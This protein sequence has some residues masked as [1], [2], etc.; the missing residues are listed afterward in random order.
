MQIEH[1]IVINAPP[2]CIF[3]L[4]EDVENWNRWDPDTKSSCIDGPFQKGAKGSLTPTVGNMV[5]MVL[6]DV[7]PGRSFTAESKIP[8]FRMV[9]EHEITPDGNNIST[10]VHRVCFSGALSWL[11]GRLIARRVDRGLPVTLAKLKAAAE[12]MAVPP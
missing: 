12:A 2:A 6:I 9:F 3:A 7:I 11:L 4:Y 1:S 5:P 8:M 10:V